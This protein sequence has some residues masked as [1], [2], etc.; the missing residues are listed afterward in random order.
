MTHPIVYRRAPDKV[1]YETDLFDDGWEAKNINA[2]GAQATAELFTD[3][4]DD[5][6]IRITVGR[7]ENRNGSQG[8][9]WRIEFA[10]GGLAAA[11][12]DAMRV[13]TLTYPAGA[14]MQGIKLAIDGI[15]GW[16]ASAYFGGETG[17]GAVASMA[18][19]FAGGTPDRE[20]WFEIMSSTVATTAL[21]GIGTVAPVNAAA[22]LLPRFNPVGRLLNPGQRIW[23]NRNGTTDIPG[24]I[25]L[26]SGANQGPW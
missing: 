22:E 18:S 25:A 2:F 6:G 16:P 3:G 15:S 21:F 11:A 7:G 23:T 26:W 20:A 4:H 1:L 24:S 9:A 12:V 17:S 8:N 19:D 14:I 10:S 5:R 13:L